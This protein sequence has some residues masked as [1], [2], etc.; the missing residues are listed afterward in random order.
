M[1]IPKSVLC[2][3]LFAKNRQLS[4]EWQEDYMPNSMHN[5]LRYRVKSKLNE[6]VHEILILTTNVGSKYS[7]ELRQN[8]QA[9]QSLH[10]SH[11]QSN[12]IDK[13]SGKILASLGYCICMLH[14]FL[15]SSDFCPLLITFANSL[16]PDQDQQN[17]G[18]DLDQNRLTLWYCS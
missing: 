3:Y 7:G 9:S 11:T 8:L 5:W 15:A 4:A 17:T 14:S 12:G 6:P 16:D 2:L 1:P 13:D 10:C 18:P